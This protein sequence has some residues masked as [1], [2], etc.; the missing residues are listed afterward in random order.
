MIALYPLLKFMSD[1]L[2]HASI[3]TAA[4][5]SRLGESGTVT[6]PPPLKL[7]ACPTLPG[8]YVTWPAREPL[9]TLR[10]SAA[11]PSPPHQPLRFGGSDCARSPSS[12]VT[13]RPTP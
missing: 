6:C 4:V 8:A 13:V 12:S 11:V 9:L 3:V 10:K 7:N 2:T 1:G 5:A